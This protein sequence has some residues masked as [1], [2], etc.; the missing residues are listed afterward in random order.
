MHTENDSPFRKSPQ[1]AK[2]GEDDDGKG[3]DNPGPSLTNDRAA[4]EWI[5]KIEEQEEEHER[6]RQENESSGKHDHD[7]PGSCGQ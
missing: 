5:R 4:Y 2:Q 3:W 7:K 1:Y 6:E